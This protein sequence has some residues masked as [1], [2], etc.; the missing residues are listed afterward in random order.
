RLARELAT[1]SRYRNTTEQAS[2]ML[3]YGKSPTIIQHMYLRMNI[4]KSLET[5]T[6]PNGETVRI[7]IMSLEEIDIAITLIEQTETYQKNKIV[8]LK[9][10]RREKYA[11]A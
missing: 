5:F 3:L 4:P 6:F 8:T 1:I 7:D 11:Q 2:F 9:R 10:V